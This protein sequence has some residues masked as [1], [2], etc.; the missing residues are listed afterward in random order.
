MKKAQYLFCENTSWRASVVCLPKA[1]QSH[2]VLLPHWDSCKIW[3]ELALFSNLHSWQCL[4]APDLSLHKALQSPNVRQQQDIET[5]APAVYIGKEKYKSRPH[6]IHHPVSLLL[7]YSS[8]LDP[9]LGRTSKCKHGLYRVCTVTSVG[10]N[11]QVLRGV[12]SGS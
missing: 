2:C 9:N 10:G 12:R 4:S 5:P 1:L 6:M 7:A 3:Q 8:L 11:M